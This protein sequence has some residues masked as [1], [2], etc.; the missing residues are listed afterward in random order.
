MKVKLTR[1]SHLSTDRDG[2]LL[3]SKKTGKPYTRCLLDL[4]DGRKSVSGFGNK[5]TESWKEGD[6]VDI[7]L[8]QNGQYW[9]FDVPKVDAADLASR[10]AK[11]EAKVFGED[12]PQANDPSL[13]DF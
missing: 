3:V 7:N 5:T 8:V 12:V 2:N 4:E 6:T 10:V 1:I 11:L 9:N 13:D